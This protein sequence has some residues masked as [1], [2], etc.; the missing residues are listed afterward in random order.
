[1]IK[2][3]VLLSTFN[4]E[5]YIQDQLKS[6]K[7]Q[8]KVNIKIF[9]I[10]D[11]SKDNTI[12]ILKEFDIPK[13]IYKS[14]KFKNPIKN[15]LHLIDV[16]PNNYDF[17]CFADQDDY[18]LNNKLAYSISKL[19][20]HDAEICGS[21]TFYTNEKLQI[22]G[23]SL[24]F[25]KKPCLK[26]ALVQ[27]ITGGNT[28]VW[29]RKFN[30]ILKKIK[31]RNPASHDWYLY[32][33]ATLF[34]FK[35]LYIKRPLIYYR[36]HG[37]NVIGSNTGLINT[38]KRVSLGFNGRF[39]VWHDM[40]ELHLR[41]IIN[42]FNIDKNNIDKINKFYKFRDQ[43]LFKRIKNFFLDLKVFRQTFRGNLM[44]F[45]AVIFKKI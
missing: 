4:G 9:A 36:Q 6:I 10:D 22:I 23:K 11:G 38:L 32:Q 44:L 42:H 17:Y 40:N 33:T 29:T 18:W 37:D 26:N 19:K 2:V 8:K 25:K 35:F 3:A 34:N 21:R 27:S 28:Q 14:K 39:K 20:S 41:Y 13:K 7:N 1:M 5:R 16:V 24:L 30:N 12:K 15:F 31:K 45:F 43:S